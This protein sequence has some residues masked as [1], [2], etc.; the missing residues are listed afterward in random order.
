L[1]VSTEIFGPAV[2]WAGTVATPTLA[3]VTSTTSVHRRI[4]ERVKCAA[5]VMIGPLRPG[6]ASP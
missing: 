3:R 5:W 2:A 1:R 4:R 6:F